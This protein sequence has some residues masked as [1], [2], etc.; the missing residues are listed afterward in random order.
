MAHISFFVAGQMTLFW[1]I[2]DSQF[3]RS[4]N[5]AINTVAVLAMSIGLIWHEKSRPPTFGEKSLKTAFYFSN[6]CLL[7]VPIA[8]VLIS[9]NYQYM[10]VLLLLQ[11]LSVLMMMGGLQSLLMSDTIDRHYELSIRDPL[12][13]IYN[14]R[15]FFEMVKDCPM[16]REQDPHSIVMCDI[17]FFKRIND[18]YGH[19][20]GDQVIIEIAHLITKHT[21]TSGIAARFGGEEFTILLYKHGLAKGLDFAEELRDLIR[22]IRVNTE[23]GQIRVTASFGVAEIWDLPDIDLTIKLADQAMLTAKSD[24]RNRVCSG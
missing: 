21:G 14:R 9:N 23:K 15:Y 7:I 18:N 22:G 8:Y 11:V 3:F 10:S 17:D 16:D 2:D 20:I 12:T 6:L 19:D 5:H 1:L 24:G 4:I 13:G